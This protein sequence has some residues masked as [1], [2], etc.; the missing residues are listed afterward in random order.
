MKD[1]TSQSAV[2]EL[3]DRRPNAVVYLTAYSLDQPDLVRTLGHRNARI[4][5]L[6]DA[7]QTRE[8]RTKMQLPNLME[9]KM[10][11]GGN[12]AKTY[13]ED[14]R[15]VW[16]VERNPA[17]QELLGAFASAGLH[18]GWLIKLDNFK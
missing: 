4:Q 9:V 8:S 18:G 1:R 16:R 14:G 15:S 6:A 12:L 3:L 7:G 11:R 17:R 5:I 13:Q 2:M 10:A